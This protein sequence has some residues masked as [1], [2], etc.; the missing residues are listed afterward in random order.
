[1]QQ[2]DEFDPLTSKQNLDTEVAAKAAKREIKNILNS[3]VGWYDPFCEL[4]QNALDAVETKRE[5]NLEGYN[6][7][8]W[9]TI[10]IKDNSLIVTDNGIGLGKTQFTQ[11]LASN[12]SFKSGNRRGHKGVGATYL[13]YGFNRINIATKT[14][15]FQAHG[16]MLDARKWLDDES[17]A[18]NPMVAF[19]KEAPKDPNFNSIESGVSIYLKFDKT[20]H[21]KQLSWIQADKAEQWYALL[22]AKTGVGAIQRIDPI[23][24]NVRVID[25]NG[26]VDEYSRTE[27]A[28]E[29]LWQRTGAKAA[30]YKEIE[31]ISNELHAKK[32]PNYTL[33]SKYTNLD[34]IYEAWNSDE[35]KKLVKLDEDDLAV[36]DKYTPYIAVEYAYSSKVWN[37]YN[38]SLGIR[39]GQQAM[40]PGIQIAANNM[41]QGETIQIPLVRYTGRQNQIHFLIHFDNC[42]AD[43]GR[44]GFRKEIADFAKEVSKQISEA[45]LPKHRDCLRAA[46]G[47]PLDLQRKHELEEWKREME[48][49]QENHPLTLVSEHF[50]H[51]AKKISVL[52]VPTREQDVISLFNQMLAGGVIRGIKIMSTNERFTYDGMYRVTFDEPDEQHIHNATSN[53]LGVAKDAAEE[54]LKLHFISH[55]QILEYK[56]SLDGLI[57]DFNTGVKNEGEIDLAVVWDVGEDYQAGYKITSLLNDE[58]LSLRPFHGVTHIMTNGETGGHVMYLI[59]LSELIDSLQDPE[60]C[61]KRQIEKYDA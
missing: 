10:D 6:P 53:P 3:Y 51:P 43:L 16:K 30:S 26:N 18:G 61:K 25:N 11:F 14:S 29:F 49:H 24:V 7:E 8:I 19:D 12:V 58:N 48:A 47:S 31:K 28:Y 9:I 23:K 34:F 56:F 40:S 13:A 55:P 38:G 42:S 46:T 59:V 37:N 54:F 17:P 52:S 60:G 2:F 50:F 33:P 27:I 22:T 41:P 44:K 45:V 39:K 32:G 5:Q 20:T 15:D 35:L 4:I 21:P 1:M 57:E 36:C